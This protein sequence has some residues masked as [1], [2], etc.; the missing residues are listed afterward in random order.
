MITSCSFYIST[1]TNPHQNL[2]VEKY[3][4]DTL[5]PQEICLYL[6]Q[7]RHTV[8]IGRNQNCWQECRVNQLLADGG[9]LARRLSGGGA[10]YHDLGNLNFTFLVPTADYDLERQLNVILTALHSLGI[11]AVKSGRND[12]EIGGRKFS[13]NAFYSSNDRSYH[14]GTL[15]LNADLDRLSHYL[16]VPQDKL[17][18]KGVPSVRARVTNLTEHQPDLTL[19][20]LQQA[21]LA[22]LA[23][24]YAQTPVRRAE[25]NW[26]RQEIE[27]SSQFFASEPW[28]YNKHLPF[29]WR[30]E[31]RFP[32][33]GFTL[34]LQVQAG[35]IQE[36]ACY[37]D[38]L[39]GELIAR[40]PGLLRGCAF[41]V[42]ALQARLRQLPEAQISADICVLIEAN[43]Y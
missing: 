39:D 23:Q 26:D 8:V 40:I 31:Q 27:R 20:Q 22:A 30:A 17:A 4:L 16:N 21:L 35:L 5:G 43:L 10:V 42:A 3:L 24:V 37:S 9:F 2:A 19:V 34:E 32:W 14:H 28:L 38:A 11:A 29:T 7:N 6:W 33:G 15:M 13:G 18:A 1:E 12:L 25:E 36:A 41:T